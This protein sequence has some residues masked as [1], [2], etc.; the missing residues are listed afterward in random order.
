M[1]RTKCTCIAW[2]VRPRPAGSGWVQHIGA[3]A[4]LVWWLAAGIFCAAVVAVCHLPVLHGY[5]QADDFLWLQ[6]SSWADVRPTLTG[7]WG[8]GIAYRP[9]IRLSYAL[10][11]SLHG[12]DAG[13]WHATNLAL[14]AANGMLLASIARRFG[15]GPEGALAVAA[16]FLTFPIDWENVDWIS[17]R[18]ALIALLFCLLAMRSW[19]RLMRVETMGRSGLAV[20]VTLQTLALMSYEAA[21]ALPLVFAC[22]GPL[23]HRRYGVKISR[24]AVGVAL[25]TAA[26]VLFWLVRAA[27]LGT[28]AGTVDGG[29]AHNLLSVLA[30]HIPTIAAYLRRGLAPVGC[31]AM[32]GLLGAGIA[33]RE[34]R[35]VVGTLLAAAIVLYLPFAP[36][37]GFSYRFLYLSTAPLAA[38]IV[39][40]STQLRS[41]VLRR[42]LLSAIMVGFGLRS[43]S[44]A[45]TAEASGQI[46]KHILRGVARLAPKDSTVVFDAVPYYN[47]GQ[48]LLMGSF[49]EA[50][51]R[52]APD[53]RM[54]A[55]ADT[56]LADPQLLQS[57]MTS[58]SRFF[59]YDPPSGGFVQIT[60]LAWEQRHGLAIDQS[61][62]TGTPA[63]P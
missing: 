43:H 42:V 20:V 12:A 53:A 58:P 21:I 25:P 44:D 33:G 15:V 52:A 3:P 6:H 49:R 63:D 7:P 5:F 48:Y 23:I 59:V 34:T 57:V 28:A 54:V 55:L 36:I 13:W 30:G 38:A 47:K 50:A 62:G 46:V 31:L 51:Q 56:V 61:R 1:Q 35:L 40:S 26:A 37:D 4:R 24:L 10:D 17:G 16:I 14:H 2:T 22:F 60:R 9:L 39:C 11:A 41:A 19:V 8:A 45:R 27:M 18:T 32:V 29:V